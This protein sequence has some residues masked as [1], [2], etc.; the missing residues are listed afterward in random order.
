MRAGAG[1][2]ALLVTLALGIACRSRPTEAG[3]DA[4]PPQGQTPISNAT[5]P[6]CE[7]LLPTDVRELMLPGFTLKEE[8]RTCPSCGPLCT[9]RS[10]SEKDV[11]V[12]VTWD[13]Q[14]HYAQADT[15]ALLEPSLRAGGEEVTALGRAA[16]RRAPAQGMLQVMAWDDDTPCALVVTWLGGDPEQALDVARTALTATRPETFV[17]VVTPTD[18]G[19][20]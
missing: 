11:S 19:T 16:A 17:P 8:T 12:S 1:R 2:A 6:A 4:G 9:F 10:A 13:C 20:P 5:L 15:H 3:T 7:A 14:P 18:A